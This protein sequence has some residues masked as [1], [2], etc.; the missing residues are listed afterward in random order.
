VCHNRKNITERFLRCLNEQVYDNWYLVIVDDGSDDGTDLLINKSINPEKLS[1]IKGDG[2]LWWNGGLH[3]A[4]AHLLSKEILKE[5]DIILIA[6]DD[7][8]FEKDIF[9]KIFSSV[10]NFPDAMISGVEVNGAGEIINISGV[11]IDWLRLKFNHVQSE[12][13]ISALPTRFL[14]MSADVFKNNGDF[15]YFLLPHYLSDYEYTIRAK[16]NGY[17]LMVDK[18]VN[19]ASVFKHSGSLGYHNDGFFCVLRKFF[20]N[21]NNVNPVR[22]SLFIL[23]SCPV[24]LKTINIVRIWMLSMAKLF[25]ILIENYFRNKS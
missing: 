23:I 24:G 21:R 4:R 1:Y 16:K 19:F 10:M 18:N 6:N 2:S 3:I 8:G 14:F 12:S 22:F 17:K 15:R 7:T 25:K 5:E 13:T 20:S 9:N 11:E